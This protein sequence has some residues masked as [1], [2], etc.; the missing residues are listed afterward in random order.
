MKEPCAVRVAI[1]KK[2]SVN[3]IYEIYGV[4]NERLQLIFSG[5]L[6]LVLTEVINERNTRARN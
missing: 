3:M 1:F 2:I 4:L 5:A 6:V